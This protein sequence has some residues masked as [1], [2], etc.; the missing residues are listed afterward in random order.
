LNKLREDFGVKKKDFLVTEAV[1]RTVMIDMMRV[2]PK[3]QFC[4][5]IN[6]SLRSLF[7]AFPVI[8]T[9]NLQQ[10][11]STM[12]A[13]EFILKLDFEYSKMQ[14]LQNLYLKMRQVL[15]RDSIGDAETF[16]RSIF[17]L[18]EDAILAET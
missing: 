16:F 5:D 3:T 13:A 10:A 12:K 4:V 9:G 1:F 18:P 2:V 14:F 11:T 6:S 15:K 7:Q 17:E 8:N